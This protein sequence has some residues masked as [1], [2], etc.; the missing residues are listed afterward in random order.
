ME[1][2]AGLK[3]FYLQHQADYQKSLSEARGTV[4]ADY[5]DYLDAQWV[6]ELRDKYPVDIREK[7]LLKV[8][9]MDGED[10]EVDR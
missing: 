2:T 1:D 5:Q 9:D 6:E 4:M 8:L 10:N 7:G 3:A